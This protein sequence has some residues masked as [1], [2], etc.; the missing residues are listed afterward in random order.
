M[1]RP[2]PPAVPSA[3]RV[4]FIDDDPIVRTLARIA[5]EQFAHCEVWATD[6]PACTLDRAV[7]FRPDVLILDVRL[8]D[9]DGLELLSLF[10]QHPGLA[11]TPAI[12]C[13]GLREAEMRERLSQVPSVGVITKPFMPRELA[14]RVRRL[15]TG[16]RS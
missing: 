9:L 15:L 12:L 2:L 5:L 1:D 16:E 7:G 10:R 11:A 14:T 3:P 4:L 6:A 8:G 13:T